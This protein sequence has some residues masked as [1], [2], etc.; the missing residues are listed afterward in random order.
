M[1]VK[2]KIE[3]IESII[4]GMLKENTGTSFLD[5][6]SAYGRNYERNNKRDFKNE[7]SCLVD[8]EYNELSINY[9][10]YHY[11]INFLEYDQECTKLE[12]KFFKFAELPNNQDANWSELMEQ[13]ANLYTSYGTTNTYNYDNLLDQI[14]QYTMFSLTNN[15]YDCYILLQIHGGCDVRGG[16]TKPRIFKVSD[17]DMF[18]IAQSDCDAYCQNCNALW[19]SDDAGYHWYAN[20]GGIIPVPNNQTL[21]PNLP[22]QQPIKRDFKDATITDNGVICPV[23]GHKL[24]FGV[25]ENC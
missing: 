17:R 24:K 14:I 9:N 8:T 15:E 5:S 25:S 3:S 4:D 6:G 1:A 22:K 13:F 7:P 19:E 20:E 11:L 23:C 18:I 16:Y 10:I 21:L 12:R 2:N